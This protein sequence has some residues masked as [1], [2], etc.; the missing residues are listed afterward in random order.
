[1]QPQLSTLKALKWLVIGLVSLYGGLMI[2]MYLSGG[3]G[4][5]MAGYG[6]GKPSSFSSPFDADSSIT[7]SLINSG[8]ELSSLPVGLRIQSRQYSFSE[9][10]KL[11]HMMAGMFSF[12]RF[13][14]IKKQAYI[15]IKCRI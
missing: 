15:Q 5:S 14:I 4:K 7:P 6:R 11:Y 3:G 8:D 9:S 10:N 1:M 2:I 13:T 12:F